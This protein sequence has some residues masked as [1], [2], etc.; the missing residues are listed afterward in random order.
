METTYNPACVLLLEADRKL[1][2][3]KQALVDLSVRLCEQGAGQNNPVD[4]G[5]YVDG[6][7]RRALVHDF[8]YSQCY[9]VAGARLD[10]NCLSSNLLLHIHLVAVL[11]DRDNREPVLQTGN[12]LVPGLSQRARGI[13]RGVDGIAG[14]IQEHVLD[15]VEWVEQLDVVGAVVT[16]LDLELE[17]DATQTRLLYGVDGDTDGHLREMPGRHVHRPVHVRQVCS[18]AIAFHFIRL[19]GA[20]ES[21]EG[22][23][24][25]GYEP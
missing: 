12:C 9:A 10:R 2:R 8:S 24:K 4:A 5:R 6:L 23:R 13:G 18:D 15:L 1:F 16:I 20:A 19:R 17:L 3:L 11:M 22:R 7:G 21:Q 25:Q 14:A